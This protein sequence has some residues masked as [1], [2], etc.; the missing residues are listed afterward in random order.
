MKDL[1]E[2]LNAARMMQCCIVLKYGGGEQR[3]FVASVWPE[4]NTIHLSHHRVG[5]KTR[6]VTLEGVT[7]LALAGTNRDVWTKNP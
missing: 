5:T 2:Y 7:A 3:G 6:P 4:S 1:Y